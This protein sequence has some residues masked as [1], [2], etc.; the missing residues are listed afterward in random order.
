M[1]DFPDW[2]YHFLISSFA[3]YLLISLMNFYSRFKHLRH[4][5]RV[6]E[7]FMREWRAMK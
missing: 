3:F 4:L 5:R 1:I 6:N 2:F 7:R